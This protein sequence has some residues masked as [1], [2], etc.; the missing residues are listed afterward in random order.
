MAQSKV[1]KLNQML[2][3]GITTSE[4]LEI[5]FDD[6]VEEEFVEDEEIE[7]EIQEPVARGK[8]QQQPKPQNP[9]LQQKKPNEAP[10]VSDTF[11]DLQKSLG[12][13][14]PAP[15]K[16]KE[17]EEEKISTRDLLSG[18][19][20]DLSS[21]KI[22]TGVPQSLLN[23]NKQSVL[24]VQSTMQVVCCQSSYAAQISA[25]RN[26]EIQNINN[27]NADLY[28]FKKTLYKVIWRHIEDS[29]V[30]KM[31]FDTWLRVTS[32]FDIETLLYGAYCM[33]F[34]KDNKYPITCPKGD[35][36]HNFDIVVNNNSLIE[37]RPDAFE[38]INEV[39]SNISRATD[40]VANSKVHTT[41][42]IM[43]E[44]SKIIVDIQIP[45]LYDY[46]ED[47]LKRIK[48]D[49]EFA[50][51]NS[52]SI[53]LAMFVKQALIPDI[54]TYRNTGELQYLPITAKQ[55]LI[56]LIANLPFSDGEVLDKEISSYTSEFLINYSIRGIKCPKC[57][58]EFP[59]IPM[60]MERVLFI[61][62]QRGATD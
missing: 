50:E 12:I 26:Q 18:I 47:I 39:V 48:N 9:I 38:K 10:V 29:S 51:E 11:A 13:G 1:D 60:D 59:S 42:R 8:R 22:A 5:D 23:A 34:P 54:E 44:D 49:Q 33:T 27:L 62:I 19:K 61:A 53:S 16:T 55:D 52:N 35:C 43:L 14:S 28:T 30:G 17:P 24:D 58:F 57:G 6:E 2:N 31:D 7:V 20:V 4:E 25:L 21:I 15:Q 56:D 37:A 40:L 46:L 3:E 41:Q 45:S 32:F 36:G